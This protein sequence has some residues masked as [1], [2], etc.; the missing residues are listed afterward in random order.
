[1]TDEEKAEFEQ[2]TVLGVDE[3]TENTT[4]SE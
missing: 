2:S 4:V 3:A 1:L